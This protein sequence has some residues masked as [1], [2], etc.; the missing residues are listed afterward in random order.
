M[1]VSKECLACIRKDVLTLGRTLLRSEDFK[2]LKDR[3]ERL[4][5]SIEYHRLP[6]YY[7]TL[8]HRILKEF[9]P[10]MVPL[11]KQRE[12]TNQQVN[13]IL[14][15]FGR[16]GLKQKIRWAT[17]AN[18]L[19]FRT[20]GVGYRFSSFHSLYKK[21]NRRL[22]VDERKEII[23]LIKGAQHI[24]YILDN[25][26]EIGFDRLLIETIGEERKVICVVRGGIITSDVIREDANF[27][28]INK[29]ARV[30]ESG[31]DTLGILKEELSPMLKK[32]FKECDLVI[33][34]G[35]AN[36]YFFS[37]YPGITKARVISLFTTKCDRVA[38]RF[39]KTGKIG[40]AKVI[41]RGQ[42]PL[43]KF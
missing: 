13:R 22:A 38:R 26:G 15:R 12:L 40:I 14:N 21:L 42:P 43:K 20:A 1:V 5:E 41:K 31:P 3:I 37:Q 7:I 9:D 8:A 34:K 24:L 28:K 6:S 19:D 11:I 16:A 25:V 35:Q 4:L 18:S 29:F 36:Y 10:E 23:K 39:G 32:E 27:F 17:W 30:I 33:A 2:R